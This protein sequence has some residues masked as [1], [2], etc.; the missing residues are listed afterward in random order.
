MKDLNNQHHDQPSLANYFLASSPLSSSSSL[1]ESNTLTGAEISGLN[2]HGSSRHGSTASSP[3][4]HA[5]STAS[6]TASLPHKLRHKLQTS[7]RHGNDCNE[8]AV[9]ENASSIVMRQVLT[10][11]IGNNNNNNNSLG[12]DSEESP[13]EAGKTEL[14]KEENYTLRNELQ[15]LAT[16]VASLKTILLPVSSANGQQESSASTF[17][18]SPSS[19]HNNNNQQEQEEGPH[20]QD[21]DTSSEKGSTSALDD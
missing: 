2:S 19:L 11:S 8:N 13:F 18:P 7:S 10:N 3:T 9:N 15:R 17:L 1:S 12:G 21:M 6:S 4:G 16:E 14:L 5:S 20:D